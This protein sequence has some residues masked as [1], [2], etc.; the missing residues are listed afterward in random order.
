MTPLQQS[1][2]KSGT[3]YMCA[4]LQV[5][6]KKKNGATFIITVHLTASARAVPEARSHSPK[7]SSLIQNLQRGHTRVSRAS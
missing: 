4:Q 7:H 1:C 5:V 2:S 6:R 3:V